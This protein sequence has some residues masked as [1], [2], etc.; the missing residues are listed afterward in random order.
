MF[1]SYLL[2]LKIFGILGSLVLTVSQ[3]LCF[4]AMTQDHAKQ[5]QYC[6]TSIWLSQLVIRNRKLSCFAF[7]ANNFCERNTQWLQSQG[8]FS[9]LL[10]SYHD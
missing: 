3:P 1:L 9:V 6:T 5:Q 8:R 4:A 10:V 2:L 7:L